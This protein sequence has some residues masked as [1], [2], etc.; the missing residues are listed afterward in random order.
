MVQGRYLYTVDLQVVFA[1]WLELTKHNSSVF[2]NW[3]MFLVSQNGKFFYR[4]HICEV[5][6]THNFNR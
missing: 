4:K 3:R 6:Q 1:A 5:L 2:G